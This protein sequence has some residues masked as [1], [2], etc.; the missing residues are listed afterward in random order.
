MLY[1][2]HLLLP[3]FAAESETAFTSSSLWEGANTHRATSRFPRT[4]FPQQLTLSSFSSFKNS[5]NILKPRQNFHFNPTLVPLFA[6][7]IH[8]FIR[9]AQ[10]SRTTCKAQPKQQGEMMSRCLP[11]LLAAGSAVDAAVIVPGMV[12]QAP[13]T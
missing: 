6:L 10:P 9:L 1:A 13:S 12:V 5:L 8:S 3:Q 4:A 11:L 2:A 7:Q